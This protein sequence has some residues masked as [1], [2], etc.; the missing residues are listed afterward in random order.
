M[1]LRQYIIKGDIIKVEG[2]GLYGTETHEEHHCE[3]CQYEPVDI[4][5]YPCIEC[6]DTDKCYWIPKL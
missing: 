4:N 1:T 2:C 6:Y 3:T 5:E